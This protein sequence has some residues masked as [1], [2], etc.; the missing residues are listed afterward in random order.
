MNSPT[1]A[2]I[3]KARL[4][5]NLTKPQ[6]AALIGVSLRAWEEWEAGRTKMH[7]AFWQAWVCVNHH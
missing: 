4:A 5:L 3:R 1:P 7:P 6:A 2:Q